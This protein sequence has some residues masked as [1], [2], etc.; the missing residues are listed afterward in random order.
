L[1]SKFV[2]IFLVKFYLKAAVLVCWSNVSGDSAGVL[3]Y[4]GVCSCKLSFFQIIV[5]FLPIV[6]HDNCEIFLKLC[7]ILSVPHSV[8]CAV[9]YSANCAVLFNCAVFCNPCH[10]LLPVQ[11]SANCAVFLSGEHLPG[12]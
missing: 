7:S 1:C 2:D 10:T 12:A 6:L 8:I 4:C 9:R 3:F 5:Q 11:Y